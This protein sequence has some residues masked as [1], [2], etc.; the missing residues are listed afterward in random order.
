M[1]GG[2]SP[3]C[4]ALVIVAVAAVAQSGLGQNCTVSTIV[5][6]LDKH[7]RPPRSLA[8]DQLKAEIGG[9]PAKVSSLSPTS[10]PTVILMLDASGSLS[11]TWDESI[12]M[13]RELAGKV[14]D[15]IAVFV[16]GED[17]QDRAIGLTE[18]EKLLDRWSTKTPKGGT[19]VFDALIKTAGRVT[20]RNTAFIVISDGNDNASTHTSDQTV[21]LFLRSSWP[22]VFGFIHGCDRRK[23]PCGH[24]EKIPDQTGGFVA[25]PSSPSEVPAAAEELATVVLS[26]LVLTLQSPRPITKT[27]KL[28][29]EVIAPDGKPRD[30]IQALHAA[31]VTSCDTAPVTSTSQK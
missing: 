14:G 9:S 13:A 5:R 30:D 27:A 8:A 24:F 31:E 16:F 7:G 15:E 18:T 1:C 19:A 25:Y 4:R 21:S 26:P 29:L 2:W 10:K 6:L 17:F 20:D 3:L 12:S 22:P 23:T 11:A 28:K